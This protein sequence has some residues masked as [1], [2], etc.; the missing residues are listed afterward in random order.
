MAAGVLCEMVLDP[1]GAMMIEKENASIPLTELLQSPNEAIGEHSAVTH[2]T[3]P[4]CVV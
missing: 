2:H 4:V 3:H 1:E